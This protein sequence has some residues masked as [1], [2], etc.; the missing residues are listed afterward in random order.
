MN[1]RQYV[2]MISNRDPTRPGERV[3]V[4]AVSLDEARAKLESDYGEGTDF[5]LHSPE[6]ADRPRKS[7]G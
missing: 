1:A 7:D 3:S 2:A 6:D 5:D 4:T